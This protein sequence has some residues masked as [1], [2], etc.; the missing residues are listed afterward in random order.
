TLPAANRSYFYPSV[1]LSAII[2]E[3]VKLPEIIDYLKIRSSWAMVGNDTSPYQLA[4]VYTST[5]SM[6]NGG[7]VLELKLPDTSPLC[8]MKPEET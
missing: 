1:S 4:Y 5:T 3:M 7:S 8:D 2:S 6:V